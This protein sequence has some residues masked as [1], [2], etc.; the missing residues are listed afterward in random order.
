MRPTLRLGICCLLFLVLCFMP[1]VTFGDCP[2][3]MWV[4]HQCKE[5][6]LLMAL[7][8][9]IYIYQPFVEYR[10]K[11]S[12]H[13]WN[14]QQQWNA[15]V[16]YHDQTVNLNGATEMWNNARSGSNRIPFQLGVNQSFFLILT[17][18]SCVELRRPVSVLK[19]SLIHISASGPWRWQTV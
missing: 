9:S 1:G 13:L 12:S 4:I 15:V 11:W 5:V 3:A 19:F 10:W 14:K 2:D 17:F 6:V 8:K 7:R 18:R 16:G